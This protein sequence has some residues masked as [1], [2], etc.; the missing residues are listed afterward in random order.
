[1][2]VLLKKSTF[3]WLRV[4][5]SEVKEFGVSRNGVEHAKK[6]EKLFKSGKSKSKKTFKSQNLAK[7][8]KKLSKSRNS[9][10]FNAIEDG[11]K[12]LTIDAKITFNRL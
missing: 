11:P 1:M 8:G 4:G 2:I 9:T 5:N 6:L 12:F 10:N 7:S 3:E